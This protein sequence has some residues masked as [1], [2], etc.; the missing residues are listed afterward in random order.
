M[1]SS[2][3]LLALFALFQTG[4]TQHCYSCFTSTLSDSRFA[5]QWSRNNVTT[6][7]TVSTWPDYANCYHPKA[8]E[9]LDCSGALGCEK[10]NAEVGF[11][12]NGEWSTFHV[13]YLGCASPSNTVDGCTTN[14]NQVLDY[15]QP[16]KD[17][18]D[19]EI[20]LSLEWDSVL[21]GQACR[22]SGDFC[23]GASYVKMSYSLMIILSLLTLF[24]NRF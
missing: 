12:Y 11:I 7:S 13:L 9:P 4:S 20:G 15:L 18:I 14:P 5:E 2:L 21:H 17:G 10:L 23:N 22:C 24:W 16:F 3:A 8:L 1:Y 19:G 6:N